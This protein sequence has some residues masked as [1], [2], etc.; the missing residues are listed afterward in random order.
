ML[1]PLFDFVG[2]TDLDSPRPPPADL[3]GEDGRALLG[4]GGRE[5][6][7]FPSMLMLSSPNGERERA[8]S[9]AAAVPAPAEDTDTDEEE[10]EEER[11][12]CPYRGSNSPGIKGDNAI[13]CVREVFTPA[14]SGLSCIPAGPATEGVRDTDDD[15]DDEDEKVPLLALDT[16]V[17]RLPLIELDLD[18]DTEE[19]LAAAATEGIEFTPAAAAEE[20]FDRTIPRPLNGAERL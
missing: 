15:G 16:E 5:S 19:L 2:L 18:I 3:Y 6:S 8:A 4:L 12:L 7:P 13:G 1:P 11:M 9:P 10:E 14:R 20:L 17:A